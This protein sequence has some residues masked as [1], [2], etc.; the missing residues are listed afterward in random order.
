LNTIFGKVIDNCRVCEFCDTAKFIESENGVPAQLF[1]YEIEELVCVA[2][3][4][5]SVVAE[6]LEY[7]LDER[8]TDAENVEPGFALG[9]CE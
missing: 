4:S 2:R 3:I 9:S 8:F 1:E 7:P 6:Y 5:F